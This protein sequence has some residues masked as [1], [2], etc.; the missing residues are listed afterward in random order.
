MFERFTKPARQAVLDAVREAERGRADQIRPE[1]LLLALLAGDTRSA[2]ILASA[3][4]TREIMTDEIAAAHRRA[5]LTDA[6]AAALGELGIDVDAIVERIEQ[7]HGEN[8]L[9]TGPRRRSL[10]GLGHL[11]FAE[12][13]KRLLEGALRQVKERRDPYLG[14]EHLLLALAAGTGIAA[15]VLANHGLTHA[16]IRTR[17]AKAS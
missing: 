6:E 5:G 16:E 14:D 12:E 8:A 10:F 1:H 7:T 13:S 9:A 15:Q 17:L 4:L 3:G 2:P 11:P